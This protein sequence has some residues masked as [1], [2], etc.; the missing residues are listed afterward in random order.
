MP[1][2]SPVCVNTEGCTLHSIYTSGPRFSYNVVANQ[3]T[4]PIYLAS[5]CQLFYLEHSDEGLREAVKGAAGF[6]LVGKVELP[7][8][9]LHTQQGEDD[10]EE[11]EEEQQ[12][13]N[14]AHRIQE[15]SHQITERCPVSRAHKIISIIISYSAHCV[16]SSNSNRGFVTY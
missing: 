5:G 7:S 16:Q 14:G 10:N 2:D 3:L 1:P 4:Q 13:G 6:G 11:E 9:H 15:G 12:A 8:K